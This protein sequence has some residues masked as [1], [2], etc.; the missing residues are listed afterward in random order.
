MC[1]CPVGTH[2]DFPPNGV[3]YC[4]PNLNVLF[5]LSQFWPYHELYSADYLGFDKARDT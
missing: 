5:G 2:I 3:K 4:L 1:L